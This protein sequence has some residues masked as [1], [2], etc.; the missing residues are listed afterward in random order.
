[1]GDCH[2]VVEETSCGSSVLPKAQCDDT[3][4]SL[5][6]FAERSCP[7]MCGKCTSTTTTTVAGF[8]ET[9]DAPSEQTED[10]PS[11]KNVGVGSGTDDIDDRNDASGEAE[12]DSPAQSKSSTGII[13]GIAFAVLLVGIVVGGIMCMR[14]KKPGPQQAHHTRQQAHHT[15]GPPARNNPMFSRNT[16][17]PEHDATKDN[18]QDDVLSDPYDFPTLKIV[19]GTTSP[20]HA[21]AGV[22][23][24]EATQSGSTTY[25][26]ASGGT[27]G[28][29][30]ADQPNSQAQYA[31]PGFGSAGAM[32][33]EATQRGST[34]YDMASDGTAGSDQADQ[35]NNQTVYDMAGDG[36]A[37]AMYDEATQSGSTTYDTASSGPAGSDHAEQQNSQTDNMVT[38]KSSG[39]GGSGGTIQQLSGSTTYMANS[40]DDL[41]L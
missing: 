31:M 32:Y 13:V 19:P 20:S 12:D 14:K 39:S 25:D 33:D 41:E 8:K 23:Y 5:K 40:D 34:T 26:M 29:N 11:K 37:G 28:S 6:R 21:S 4:E 18:A 24:D 27:A 38:R 30:Q 35:P 36:S 1:M 17:D 15:R 10:G 7:L 9:G 22:V 3:I 16:A 2:G